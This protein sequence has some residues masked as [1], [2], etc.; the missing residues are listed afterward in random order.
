MTS[1]ESAVHQRLDGMQKQIDNIGPR[2]DRTDRSGK[3]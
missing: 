1:L 3:Q 2:L